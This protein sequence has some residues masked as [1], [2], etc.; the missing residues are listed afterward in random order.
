MTSIK[1]GWRL[2]VCIPQG[3]LH[4]PAQAT[5]RLGPLLRGVC[6]LSFWALC[7]SYAHARMHAC[8]QRKLGKGYLSAFSEEHFIRLRRLQPVWAPLYEV[9]AS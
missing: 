3:A 5:A 8:T 2:P 4:A 1:A 6:S 9:C 7:I